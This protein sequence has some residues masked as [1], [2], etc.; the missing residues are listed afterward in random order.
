MRTV[1]NIIWVVFGGW[2]V[3]LAWLLASVISVIGIVTI[4]AVPACWR[5]ASYSFLPFGYTV[6]DD[7]DASPV[8]SA[9]FNIV[10]LVL[11]GWWMVLVYLVAALGQSLTIVG[12]VN[13][14]G[15]LKQIPLALMP[16]GKKIVPST[17]SAI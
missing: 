7:E 9:F 12:L 16:Y 15:L 6:V 3:A 5:M 8:G 13:A 14:V 10:W 17:Q 11:I 1:L 2:L 4:P